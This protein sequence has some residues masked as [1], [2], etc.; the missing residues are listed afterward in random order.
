MRTQSSARAL[1]GASIIV[2]VQNPGYYLGY[3]VK[4]EKDIELI[5]NKLDFRSRFDL[6]RTRNFLDI[7]SAAV[8]PFLALLRLV[9]RPKL[10]AESHLAEILEELAC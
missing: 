4:N 7:V 1:P 5:Q 9:V 6:Q 8:R 2:P 10:D 3:Q